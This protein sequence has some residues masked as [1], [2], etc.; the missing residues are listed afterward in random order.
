VN[1]QV[2][3]RLAS[4]LLKC[5]GTRVRFNPEKVADIAKAITR[6]DIRRLISKGV[7]AKKPEVGTSRARANKIAEKKKKGRR[8]GPGTRKGTPNARLRKKVRWMTKVRSQRK[9]LQEL[10]KTE[11]LSTSLSRQIYLKIKGGVFR[12][13]AHLKNFIDQIKERSE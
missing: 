6:E 11:K 1:L 5:G 2:Q 7:I 10:K 8:R 4:E 3:K 13:K 9:Y 12:S